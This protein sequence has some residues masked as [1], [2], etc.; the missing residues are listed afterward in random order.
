MSL[1]KIAGVVLGSAA[2]VAGHGYVSGAVVDGTYYGGYLITQY[3]YTS[4]PPETIGWS[5]D[6]T[7]LGYIDGSEYSNSNII[8]HKDAQPGAISAPVAAGGSVELQ[9]TA[10]PESH[11][12]PVITYM[13]NCNGDCSSV[14][15][16][17]LKFFKIDEAGLIDDSNVPGTW[18]SDNL[19][20]NNNSRTVTIP[21]SI[22]A[23]NYVLR[24]EIIALHSAE[25][26]NGAQNYPQCINLKVTGGGSDSPSGTLGTA[27]YKD[28]DP[29]ILVNIY[30]SL[31]SYT[32]P[33]PALYTGAASSDSTTTTAASV[34]AST[35]AAATT[36]AAPS[37]TVASVGVISSPSA[38]PVSATPSA[39]PVRSSPSIPPFSNSTRVPRP[40]HGRGQHGS[41][42]SGHPHFSQPSEPESQPTAATITDYAT[43]TATATE[44]ATA[45]VQL[46]DS[47]VVQTPSADDTVTV[48]ASAGAQSAASSTPASSSSD[49]SSSSSSSSSGSGSGSSSTTTTTTGGS[50]SYNS[51]DWSTYLSSLSAEQF[52]SLLRQTLKWLVSDNKVHARDLTY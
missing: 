4:T 28:T 12:G 5:E 51:S 9:W 19:I 49:S 31:S 50:S 41:A 18:A 21:S 45:T 1:S 36:A 29:G 27:L 15:K 43:A 7:D 39:S 35:T 11:H 16:T 23:G 42:P 26:T 20:S 17:S 24:H 48:T 8:C 52:L 22:E 3:P 14:D 38:S 6:A 47:P 32:I 33:G 30:Q 13:A 10:W 37:S 46:T 2:L 25:N 34:A 40:S 44:Y